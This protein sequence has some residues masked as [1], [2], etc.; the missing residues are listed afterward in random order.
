MRSAIR[1]RVTKALV[2]PPLGRV[3]RIASCSPSGEMAASCTAGSRISSS[4]VGGTG[5]LPCARASAGATPG[6]APAAASIVR[7]VSIEV[8][9]NPGCYVCDSA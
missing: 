1:E 5:G 9:G 4:M 3:R 6:A 8:R 2:L 7:R